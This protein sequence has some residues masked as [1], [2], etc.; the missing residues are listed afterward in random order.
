MLQ[1]SMTMDVLISTAS[2]IG[3]ATESKARKCDYTKLS[4]NSSQE[5]N[6]ICHDMASTL[7]VKVVRAGP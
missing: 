2:A 4:R 6:I 3:S 7:S 1:D 5:K